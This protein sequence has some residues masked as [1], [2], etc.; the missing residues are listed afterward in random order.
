MNCMVSQNT[1]DTGIASNPNIGDT[2]FPQ[3]SL[4]V[5]NQQANPCQIICHNKTFFWGDYIF[6]I[7]LALSSEIP[8]IILNLSSK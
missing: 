8:Y 6:S 2:A 3:T 5:R 7:S 4:S 1:N